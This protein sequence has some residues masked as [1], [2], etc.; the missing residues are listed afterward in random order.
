MIKKGKKAELTT[1]QIVMLVVLIT[2]FA[3]I[4]FLLF[5]LNLGENTA[6][7]I[8]RNSVVMK[9]NSQ[10]PKDAVSL[11]CHTS[12]VCI[13]GDRTCESMTKP[14]IEKVK[15][16]E[17]VYEVLANEMKDCWWMFGE[18]KINYIG[19]ELKS[20][21]Y[22]SIC[23]HIGF[24]ESTKELFDSGKIDKREFYNHLS[25]KKISGD[26]KTYLEYF[27]GTRDISK[28]SEG[29]EFGE[30]DLNKQYYV[31][32]G[33]SSDTDYSKWGIGVGGVV[34]AALLVPFI[35]GLSLVSVVGILSTSGTGYYLGSIVEGESGDKYLEPIIIG[36]GSKEFNETQCKEIITFS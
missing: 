33:I 32:M 26:G 6:K 13:S 18:G 12:Y 19:E 11:N 31:L 16:K 3:I 29:R 2:S 25:N 23:S 1:Q 15:S 10:L 36:V 35:G 30:I 5:R 14:I 21:R 34:G 28:I 4:L 22:C 17:E 27:V 20:K 24:D 9:G 7:E 8:C